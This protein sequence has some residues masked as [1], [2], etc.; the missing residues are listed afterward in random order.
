MDDFSGLLEQDANQSDP[1]N[2]HRT[3]KD[4]FGYF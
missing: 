4:A 1:D 2:A 3:Q